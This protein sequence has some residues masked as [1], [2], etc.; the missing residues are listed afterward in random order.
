M[1]G[2]SGTRALIGMPSACRPSIFMGIIGQHA[3]RQDAQILEDEGCRRILTL[4]G[5]VPDHQIGI[6]GVIAH[7]LVVIGP[8]L[9]ED[10][11]P[12]AL[13]AQVDQNASTFFGDHDAWTDAVAPHSR[14]A[15][16]PGHRR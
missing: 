12:A 15:G 3:Y 1:W 13:L 5:F 8:Q 14:S 10:A 16:N 2:D 11:D 7:I 4:V 6:D 9:V